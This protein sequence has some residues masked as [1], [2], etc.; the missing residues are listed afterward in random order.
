ML[1][2]TVENF[3][4]FPEGIKGP[5]LMGRMQ[6]QA[7]RHGAR[8]LADRVTSSELAAH[9]L[10]LHTPRGA[11][12]TRAVVVATGARARWLGLAGEERLRGA[13]LHTCARCDGPLYA[14]AAVLVVGGGDAAMEAALLASRH[15]AT[16]TLV[17]R[18]A[19]FKASAAALARVRNLSNVALREETRVARWEV[20]GAGALRAAWLTP[21]GRAV[22]RV[23]CSGAFIAIGRE[24]ATAF[25]G[26][27]VRLDEAGYVELAR[28]SRTSVDGVFACGDA[29]DAR[30]R[31]AVTAAGAGAQAAMDVDDW[32]MND[33]R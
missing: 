20:D 33:D 24:P 22:E 23:A 11:V 2:S 17:H 21:R 5:D 27:A 13:H 26:G 29:A 30:Y 9:P 1:T 14:G 10:T 3:P 28:G 4:G 32:L 19:L 31:Q 15:A 6:A 18:R 16:V 25:L 8:L 12:R 7:Q